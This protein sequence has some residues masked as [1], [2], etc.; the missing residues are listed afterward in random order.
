MSNLTTRTRRDEPVGRQ[1][2]VALAA[3]FATV[4]ILLAIAPGRAAAA[5]PIRAAVT[6]GT[7]VVTGTPSADR[8]ALRLSRTLPHRLQ[9][10]I[11][12]NGS[13]DRTFALGSFARIDV[14]A[15]GGSDRI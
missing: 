2:L 3:A 11:G 12:D 15:G 13:V 14:E 1:T 9:L 8:I 10:D 7:L 4:V 6:G 5:S